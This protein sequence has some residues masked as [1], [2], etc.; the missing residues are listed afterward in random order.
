M[1]L[2]LISVYNGCREYPYRLPQM[3]NVTDS[4][5]RLI[6]ITM[7]DRIDIRDSVFFFL[8]S[9][10]F[11]FPLFFSFAIKSRE[12]RNF[13]VFFSSFLI[14]YISFLLNKIRN[15]SSFLRIV[16]K[17]FFFFSRLHF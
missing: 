5:N 17:S 7:S 15:Y 1:S 2:I 10:S 12:T 9:F 16:V 13:E 3:F 11:F 14:I 8:L 4:E 6:I